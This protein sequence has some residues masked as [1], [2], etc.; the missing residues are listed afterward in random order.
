MLNGRC[1]PDIRVPTHYNGRWN[2]GTANMRAL[3]LPGT[4]TCEEPNFQVLEH[5]S[6]QPAGIGQELIGN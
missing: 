4:G 6:V 1:K 3:N 5:V 2:S